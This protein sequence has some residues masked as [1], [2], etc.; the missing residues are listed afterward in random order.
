MADSV[1]GQLQPRGIILKIYHN[2]LQFIA[3]IFA[4]MLMSISMYACPQRAVISTPSTQS[5][6]VSVDSK[7]G[8]ALTFRLPDEPNTNYPSRGPRH[9]PIHLVE[10]LNPLA[11]DAR[12]LEAIRPLIWK[13]FPGNLR[14]IIRF[15]P[16]INRDRGYYYARALYAAHK[17]GIFWPYLQHLL[18]AQLPLSSRSLLQIAAQ[19]GVDPQLFELLLSHAPH[20]KHIDHDMRLAYDLKIT[21]H[22][23]LL[24]NGKLIMPPYTLNTVIH[25]LQQ[26][27][28]HAYQ[29]LDQGISLSKLHSAITQDAQTVAPANTYPE[30][31]IEHNYRYIPYAFLETLPSLG[32]GDALI[33]VVKFSDFTCQSSR[34][35]FEAI[36]KLRQR[37]PTQVRFYAKLLPRTGHNDSIRAAEVAVAAIEQRKF[38]QLYH[39]LFAQQARLLQ[40]EL[41]TLASQAQLDTLWLSGVLD[42]QSYRHR[43]MADS[44]HAAQLGI[45]STPAILINGYLVPQ[46]SDFEQILRIAQQELWKAGM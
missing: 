4:V 18:Q 9:A 46:P 27:Q 21:G 2:I 3:I 13:R 41:L 19:T 33:Q 25:A 22:T 23:R 38:W 42:R 34:Q 1:P 24:I 36:Q 45:R 31:I 29:I 43:V 17:L 12:S 26:A 11:P 6:Q 40:G 39:L 37:Y 15:N 16:H 7:K 5:T 28:T 10:F 44:S 32:P 35:A 20:K 30:P 8:P 14:W